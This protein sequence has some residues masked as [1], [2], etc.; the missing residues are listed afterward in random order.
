MA[1]EPSV[2]SAREI[3]VD[4]LTRRQTRRAVRLLA[5][6]F[7]DDPAWSAGSPRRSA[8]RRVAN[9]TSFRALLAVARRYGAAVRSAGA[10]GAL[11]GVAVSFDP[12]RWPPPE[13]SGVLELAWLL[14]AG[15][16]PARRAFLDDATMRRAHVSHPHLYLWVIGVD[17][18]AQRRGVGGALIE[19]VIGRAE[20]QGVPTYLE[21]ATEENVSIYRRFG[22]EPRGEIALPSGVV[23]WQLE[24]PPG[25]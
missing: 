12:G 10:D 25:G 22:F 2:R 1:S 15:P 9:R 13:R 23:M 21:T 19:D 14:I 18:A 11:E 20:A 7:H 8:H 4:A 6:A 5:E 16:A 17:P 3:E 24:R